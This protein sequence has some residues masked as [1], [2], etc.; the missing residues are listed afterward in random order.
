MLSFILWVLGSA[1]V[2]EYLIHAKNDLK[3]SWGEFFA[4]MDKKATTYLVFLVFFWPIAMIVNI[5]RNLFGFAA[6]VYLWRQ[7][8]R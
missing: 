5:L 3:L 8:R 1:L 4:G 6:S 7:T 2:I